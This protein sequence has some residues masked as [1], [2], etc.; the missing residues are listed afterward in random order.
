MYRF[1]SLRGVLVSV[2]QLMHYACMHACK[3]VE[4]LKS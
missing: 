2:I 3:S 1:V 4:R